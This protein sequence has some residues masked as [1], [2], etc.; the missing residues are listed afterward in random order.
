MFAKLNKMLFIAFIAGGR[1]IQ[2][3][4]AIV[5][6]MQSDSFF[7][8]VDYGRENRKWKICSLA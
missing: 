1:I 5:T 8:S 6:I 2:T 7:Y 3:I 4:D